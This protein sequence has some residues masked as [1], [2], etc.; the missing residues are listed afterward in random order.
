MQ[1]RI[2]FMPADCRLPSSQVAW[3]DPCV[4]SDRTPAAR[5][6]GKHMRHGFSRWTEPYGLNVH[7]GG[8]PLQPC[9]H[10]I[11]GNCD[12]GLTGGGLIALRERG[13]HPGRPTL[14]RCRLLR[15]ATMPRG[16]STSCGGTIP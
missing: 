7:R 4:M 13:P 16:R 8:L 10:R 1:L 14:R 6:P 12:V 11:A 3:P 5:L 2:R 15:R 9:W